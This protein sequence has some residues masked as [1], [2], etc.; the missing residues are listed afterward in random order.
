M[1]MILLAPPAD[2]FDGEKVIAG[3]G[4]YPYEKDVEAAGRQ[5][6]AFCLSK[7]GVGEDGAAEQDGPSS[8][9]IEEDKRK[10]AYDATKA[11]VDFLDLNYYDSLGIGH[12][13]FSADID[14]IKRGYH[15]M[16]LVHH[17]DKTGKGETDPVFLQIQDAFN[18]LSNE[19]NRRAYDSQCDF[20]DAIP[21][22]TE[23][24]KTDK[25]FLALYAPVFERNARF[26]EKKPVPMIGSS[27]T[28][29]E[30][31]NKFYDYWQKFDSWRDFTHDAEHDVDSADG[32][33]EKRW[34]MEENKRESKKK[35]K[36]EYERL[37]KL[38]E[39]AVKNDPRMI[40]WKI[41][42][43]Q[44]KADTK[45]AR[46]KK[47]QDDKEAAIQEKKDAEEKAKSDAVSAK[48][49]AKKEKVERE[50]VKKQIRKVKNLLKKLVVK[51]TGGMSEAEKLAQ[52]YS[53]EKKDVGEG[54]LSEDDVQELCEG[55]EL[56]EIVA[57]VKGFGIET[58][59]QFD[60][61]NMEAGVA[62]V[63]QC[64]IDK[65][66]S[67]VRLKR[68]QAEAT[69][70]A[71]QKE[72]DELA[73]KAK[74]KL[75]AQRPWTPE[76]LA[77]L[78]KCVNKFPGGTR[79]RWERI[80]EY[81]ATQLRLDTARPKGEILDMSNAL[82]EAR[83]SGKGGM[84]PHLQSLMKA[85][86][87]VKSNAKVPQ[88]EAAQGLASVGT[89]G[90]TEEEGGHWSAE[91]QKQFEAALKKHPSSLAAKE[92][93]KAIAGDVEGKKMKECIARFKWVR[94]QIAK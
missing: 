24:C 75:D 5:H 73:A 91:Q 13:G 42:E 7:A 54:G 90:G 46:E 86:E 65:A 56:A 45:A 76:E 49:N 2:G 17:P 58:D 74:A 40:R 15:K 88:S 11:G 83:N 55:M 44:R 69:E 22:G 51:G 20:D 67:S 85:N 92:R 37:A 33:D 10:A 16:L 70:A 35:K 64:I 84:D 61:A 47:K 25:A 59:K 48:E 53:K 36:K 30:E 41:E 21:D 14:Q 79:M 77:L 78:A 12:I 60:D 71:R 29:I 80:S 9:A 93:W 26:A 3:V 57:M 32:R 18:T 23:K 63:R 38:C 19:V 39:R 66:D 81:M 62:N 34:M 89:G 28:P 27:D 52:K 82:A 94:S 8:Q 87:W 1:V 50:K 68:E 31:I 4:G 6:A 43:K 72:K